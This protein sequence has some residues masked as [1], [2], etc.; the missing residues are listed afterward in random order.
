MGSIIFAVIYNLSPKKY[1]QYENLAPF[2]KA[3]EK[4]VPHCL[5]AKRLRENISDSRFCESLTLD[6]YSKETLYV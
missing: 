1:I 5:C 2:F 3:P 4:K 6:L